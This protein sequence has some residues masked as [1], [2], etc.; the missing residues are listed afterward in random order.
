MHSPFVFDFILNVLNNASGYHAPIKIE[1]LRQQMLSDKRPINGIDLGA[2]SRKPDNKKKV[3]DIARTALKPKKYA[4]LFYR[5]VKHYQPS[6]ILE[7]GTSLGITT[8]YLHSGN[9]DAYVITIEGNKGVAD[10]AR[11]NFQKLDLGNTQMVI[12]N[13]DDVLPQVLQNNP[14]IDLAFIDGNHRLK[15][16]LEYF[17]QLLECSQTQ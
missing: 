3:S 6:R 9:P 14:V 5:L 12:G 15:P 8:A 17:H 7:L 1:T 2:G 13:F 16:T 4:E 10:I 11:E